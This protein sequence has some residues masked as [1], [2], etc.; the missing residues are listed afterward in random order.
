MVA[1]APGSAGLASSLDSEQEVHVWLADVRSRSVSELETWSEALSDDVERERAAA[2]PD[3]RARRDHLAGRLALRRLLG[4]YRPSVLAGAWRIASDPSGRP[5][6]HATDRD[7]EGTS[8]A[9]SIAHSEGMVALALHRRAEPGI[10]IEPKGRLVDGMA[11]ARRYFA[12]HELESLQGIPEKDRL[13]LF[14]RY[15]TLKEACVKADGQ[16]LAGELARRSFSLS[17]DGCIRASRFDL[18]RW[19]YWS[20]SVSGA[21]WVAAAL[22]HPAGRRPVA[23]RC[24]Q[25]WLS[26]EDGAVREGPV[27]DG[28][29][30]AVF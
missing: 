14:L 2:M 9:F 3:P 12:R 8:P 10:D 30:S 16:G 19:Q 18:R 7:A 11:L 25:F 27:V 6:A 17:R 24:R 5:V 23:V 26:L 13:S 28:A 29:Q 15:W 4:I 1:T 20:W 21:W 22:R